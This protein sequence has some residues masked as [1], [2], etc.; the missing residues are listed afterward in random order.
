MKNFDPAILQG[1]TAN[2]NVYG[3][4]LDMGLI[5]VF[6]NKDIFA[7][8]NLSVPKTYAEFLQICKTL[9]ANNVN[10]IAMGFKEPWVAGIDFMQ[11]WYIIL[12]KH[13][14]M[15]R[16]INSGQKKFADYP[17]FRR[18][19]E[20]SRERFALATGNP[21]GSTNDQAIQMLA[22]GRAAMLAQGTWTISSILEL[23]PDGNFGLFALPADNANDTAARLF[24]D[25]AFMISSRTKNMDAIT[26]LFNFAT[27]SEG[28]NMWAEK[29]SLIPAVKG[30]TL[31]N[32]NPMV[33]DADA[34]V[35]S[36]KTI[37]ADTIFSPSGQCWNILVER[38]S[39]D[40]LADQSK[41]IDRWIADLDVEYAAAA[42]AAK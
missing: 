7:K 36:G 14:D 18:A 28:A 34:Q 17:E 35:K 23:N 22:M 33:A 42:A 11:E 41:S 19:M 29:T 13:P 15:F 24:V 10:P 40:F 6:Y 27:S 31:K 3:I 5:M 25:D 9:A 26:A 12:K 8:Y 32:P 21:F 37:F 30:I 39:A 16:Q 20:R 2:G 4:P 38:F 1:S